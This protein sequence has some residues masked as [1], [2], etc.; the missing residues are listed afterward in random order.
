MYMLRP[1]AELK[2]E[3]GI[4]DTSNRIQKFCFDKLKMICRRMRLIEKHP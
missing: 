2:L 4:F 1:S 3:T